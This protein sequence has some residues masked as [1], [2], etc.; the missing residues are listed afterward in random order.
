LRI[1]SGFAKGRKLYGPQNDKVIRPTSD[2]AKEALFNIL[3]E[4]VQSAH[5]IDF[6]AGT[7]AFGIEALS[8]GALSATF[9]DNGHESLKLLDKNLKLLIQSIPDS[10]PPPRIDV[11]KADA[12]K[13]NPRSGKMKI[14]LNAVD[15]IF[16][17]P[18]YSK[19]LAEKV[20]N[21]LDQIPDLKSDCLVIA[22]ERSSERPPQNFNYLTLIDQRRYGDTVFW[23][24]QT[25]KTL[26]C[27]TKEP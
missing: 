4:R 24:Y 17:D 19:G 7:G 13:F 10:T 1:I 18:P 26:I 22:E 27:D 9:I 3:A 6:F 8:R 23:I 15:L 20:L 11:I 14:P 5:V 16:M 2:R 12:L 25:A 21:R